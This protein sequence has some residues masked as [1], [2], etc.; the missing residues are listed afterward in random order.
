MIKKNVFMLVSLLMLTGSTGGFLN[1]WKAHQTMGEPGVR[2]LEHSDSDKPPVLLPDWV[3]DYTGED[4]PV[5][6]VEK[7][8]LPPDTTITKRRYKHPNGFFIDVMVVL[9]GLDRTSIHK[10][11]YCLT[12]A[13][14]H[15]Q[16]TNAKVIEIARPVPFKLPVMQ[17]KSTKTIE[18]NEY[19]G[20]L[21]YWFVDDKHVTNQHYERMW[22]MGKDLFTTGKMQ[23]WAY[24]TFS[25][26]VIPGQEEAGFK[27]MEWFIQ[28]AVPVFQKTLPESHVVAR[29]E[30]SEN[31]K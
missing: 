29:T 8:A 25:A 1:Y 9:M 31:A 16:Q 17:L 14:Y 22:L 21:Y 15:I 6:D 23:R 2:L 12:G 18:G 11:Q 5:S 30:G 28:N 10:P 4:L 20:L 7:D 13:G 24:I 3:L 26:I 27:H 19:S